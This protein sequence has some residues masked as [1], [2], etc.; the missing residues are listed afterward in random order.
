MSADERADAH[1]SAADET[2]LRRAIAT[3]R[4]HSAYL[5]AGPGPAPAAAALDF[6]RA[7]VCVGDPPR[8][9]ESC[10][11]CRR[12]A[13][14][15]GEIALDGSGK[16]GPLYRHVGDHPDLLW[17]GRGQEDTR[18]RIAQVRALQAALH[19]RS[20]EGKWRAAV[21]EDA[22]WLNAEAQN[23][24]LRLLEEPPPQTV[25]VL[26]AASAAGLLATLRSRCQRVRFPIP[27]TSPWRSPDASDDARQLMGRIEQIG[28]A[29]L[30]ELLDWAEEYR[31]ARA[32]ASRA[33]ELLL[34]AGG[35]WLRE[36]V[37]SAAREG[38]PGVDLRPALEAFAQL[39]AAR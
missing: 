13:A 5:L 19:L 1:T 4:V 30:P 22:E 18:V 23:A 14:D 38:K 32:D 27:D 17:L 11:S 8:P 21:I 37:R 31:G 36:R 35:F 34:E 2:P 33:V 24:L 29:S 10:T 7:L 28:A 9:C 20:Y 15:R 26:V 3:G 25:L 16:K 12:S 39:R 6:V